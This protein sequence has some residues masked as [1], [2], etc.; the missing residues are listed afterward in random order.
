MAAFAIHPPDTTLSPSR[1]IDG[2]N[3]KYQSS[4]AE[5]MERVLVQRNAEERPCHA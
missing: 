3:L 5:S 2:E 1:A 4:L